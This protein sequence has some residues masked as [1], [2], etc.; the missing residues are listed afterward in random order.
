MV[1]SPRGGLRPGQ[2]LRCA[3]GSCL[4]GAAG[5]LQ[6]VARRFLPSR[7]GCEGRRARDLWSAGPDCGL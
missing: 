6:D 1:G 5:G 4:C 3:V 2:P 7:S